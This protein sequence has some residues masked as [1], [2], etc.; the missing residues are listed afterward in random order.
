MVVYAFGRHGKGE[1]CALS[2]LS[3]NVKVLLWLNKSDFSAKTYADY[4]DFI[5][6]QCLMTPEHFRSILLDEVEASDQDEKRIRNYF[7]DCWGDLSAIKYEFLFYDLISQ[8]A[9]EILVMNLQYLLGTLKYGENA[10]FVES[11][12]VNQST[13]T[14]WKQGKTKP[15]KYAQKQIAQFFGLKDAEELKTQLLF[16]DLEPVSVQQKKVECKE[17]IDNMDRKSFELIYA[18]LKKI[19]K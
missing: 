14:R 6:K 1:E 8:S 2:E 19:L 11:I 12:G 7:N 5:A 17:L 3:S 10:E 4:I 16:L 9:D 13:L 15:D 18:A